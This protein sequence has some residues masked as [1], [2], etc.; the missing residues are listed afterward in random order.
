MSQYLHYHA[1]DSYPECFVCL[2]SPDWAGGLKHTYTFESQLAEGTTGVEIGIPEQASLRLRVEYRF[3]LP[4]AEAAE[5][6]QA[7]GVLGTR[8]LAVPLWVDEGEAE[9][10]HTPQQVL[11]WSDAGAYAITAPAESYA[12]AHA[13][14]L[15]LGVL[16]GRPKVTPLTDGLC[17]VTVAVVES[18]PW[19]CRV[20]PSA[21]YALPPAFGWSP[22]WGQSLAEMTRDQVAEHEFRQAREVGQF[23][24]DSVTRWG[25]TGGF[26]LGRTEAGSLLRFFL[27]R[28]GRVKSFAC[29]TWFRPGTSVPTAPHSGSYRFDSESLE[30]VF[31]TPDIAETDL[32]MWQQVEMDEGAPAQHGAPRANLYE[33]TWEGETPL[34]WTS[35]EA[36][37]VCDGHTY[38]P[39]LIGHEGLRLSTSSIGDECNVTVFAR[40]PGNPLAEV[41]AGEVDRELS[42]RVLR[43]DPSATTPTATT[44]FVGSVRKVGLRGGEHV[45]SCAVLGGRFRR[46][47]PKHTV[48][49]GCNYC[50]FDGPCGLVKSAWSSVGTFTGSLPGATLAFTPAT[51]IT[52]SGAYAGEWYAG[53]WCECTGTDGR[54]YRRPI[55]NCSASGGVWTLQLGR[56]LP[57]VCAGQTLTCYPGCDGRYSTCKAKFDNGLAFGGFPFT[58]IFISTSAGIAQKTSMK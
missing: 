51:G 26:I 29:D 41:A 7:L 27:D 33:L 6:R 5:F 2:L 48:Q 52:P 24:P 4:E 31:A 28:Q 10:L 45:A 17:T 36:P 11:S 22:D 8:R 18:A 12:H 57:A 3:V 20:S 44:V 39:A 58:P 15:L 50:L 14:P 43:C 16:S 30:I 40:Q 19:S 21:D 37:I 13:A 34:R 35:W 46:P 54:A 56:Q 25:Q 49:K 42:V 47:I 53:G 9:W 1:A 23:G 55:H 38:T 32:R